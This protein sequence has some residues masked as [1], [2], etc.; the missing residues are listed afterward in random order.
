MAQAVGAFGR[1]VRSFPVLR[2]L[3]PRP[4]QQRQTLGL[5]LLRQL[6]LRPIPWVPPVP[7]RRQQIHLRQPQAMLLRRPRTLPIPSSPSPWAPRRRQQIHLRQPQVMPRH[8]RLLTP[9]Q[10]AMRW[11]QLALLRRQP[12]IVRRRLL[13][14]LHVRRQPRLRRRQR[15]Q[16]LQPH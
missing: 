5:T 1:S 11:P 2:L 3:R 4:F 15:V 14:M 7:R 6:R 13:Q 10:T 8:Q 16:P 9:H 12:V